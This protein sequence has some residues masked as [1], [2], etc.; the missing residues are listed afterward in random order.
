M[1]VQLKPVA[2]LATKAKT[3]F[4]GTSPEY[5]GARKALLADEIAFRR[6]MTRLGEQRRTVPPG[7]V[8]TED[9]CFK[10]VPGRTATTWAMSTFL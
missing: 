3:P 10:P 8:I 6:H 1:N 7:P 5:E 4:P 2:E 9:Y